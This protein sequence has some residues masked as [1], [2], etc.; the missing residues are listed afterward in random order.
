MKNEN[1]TVG[2]IEQ[3]T[4]E[5]TGLGLSAVDAVVM[6]LTGYFYGHSRQVLDGKK[7]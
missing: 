2:K 3:L 5:D 7:H 6:F 4:S 1:L